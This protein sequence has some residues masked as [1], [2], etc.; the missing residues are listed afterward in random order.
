MPVLDQ[1]L[2][3]HWKAAK[4]NLNNEIEYLEANEGVVDPVMDV[5]QAILIWRSKKDNFQGVDEPVGAFHQHHSDWEGIL[6]PCRARGE[7][8]PG[9][10]P[11]PR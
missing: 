2:V 6:S 5:R 10:G 9:P 7:P 3:Y 8:G 11:G 4:S 1:S